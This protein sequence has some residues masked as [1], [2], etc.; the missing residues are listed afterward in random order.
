L[1]AAGADRRIRVALLIGSLDIG[2]AERQLV[3]LANALDRTR[4]QP[5]V[6][7]WF[8]AGALTGDLRPDV[9]HRALAFSSLRRSAGLARPLVAARVTR[10]LAREL[11]HY[12][13]DVLHAHLFTGYT[14]GAIAARLAR[15]PA[16]VAGRRGLNTYDQLPLPGPWLGRLANRLVTLHLCNSA[17]VRDFALAHERDLD[18]GRMV[19]VHNGLDAA[20]LSPLPLP[21]GWRREGE[22]L[23]AMVANFHAY[24][25]HRLVV[26]AWRRLRGRAP[27]RLVLFGAGPDEPAVRRLVTA[28]GLEGEI[29]FAGARIDADRLA[30]QFDFSLLASSEEGFPNALMEAMA[31]GV[32]VIAPT[33]GGVPELVR[34]GMDG[35]LFTPGDAGA[36]AGRVGELAADAGLRR[37]L[38]EAGRARIAA[39]FSTAAMVTGVQAAYEDAL[40]RVPR[41]A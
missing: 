2:G 28:A 35:L 20:S 30:G 23:G 39:D 38:G 25:G 41:A 7:T 21:A 34:D 32:P 24:K 1:T 22:L 13:A 10:A 8:G 12:R 31:A 18:P 33:V 17:A 9:E 40:R 6:L 36:L 11:R 15:V 16:V 27:A 37:R 14:L 4:F 29:I 19:V 5:L 26:E 3:R